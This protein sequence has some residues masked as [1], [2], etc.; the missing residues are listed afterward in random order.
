MPLCRLAKL[1]SSSRHAILIFVA[2]MM[3]GM[4][5]TLYAW[6]GTETRFAMDGFAPVSPSA[7]ARNVQAE[8]SLVPQEG[9][10]RHAMEANIAVGPPE[11]GAVVLFETCS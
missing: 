5:I 2:G 4:F 11:G 7:H 8:A 3:V 1:V 9:S 6:G 10:M